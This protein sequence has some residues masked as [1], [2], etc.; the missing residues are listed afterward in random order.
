[1]STQPSQ[2]SGWH[3]ILRDLNLTASSCETPPN[4]PTNDAKAPETSWLQA[5][6]C[7][8]RTGFLRVLIGETPTHLELYV[9]V[10]AGSALETPDLLTA[11]LASYTQTP[12]N[13]HVASAP[14]ELST[15]LP[16]TTEIAQAPTSTLR[17]VLVALMK[18]GDL[19]SSDSAAL[20]QDAIA[21]A[22]SFT[23]SKPE[24]ST[25]EP[26]HDE[27]DSQENVL[28]ETIGSSAH[29][30]TSNAPNL[31]YFEVTAQPN[32][33]EIA[34]HLTTLL[35]PSEHI[36]LAKAI[37]H[38]LRTRFDADVVPTPGPVAPTS[39]EAK[40]STIRLDAEPSEEDQRNAMGRAEL[41]K[42]FTAF[43][44]KAQEWAVLGIDIF[45]LVGLKHANSTQDVIQV[46]T[47]A[48]PEQKS[49]SASPSQPDR[50]REKASVSDG[51]DDIVFD[52]SSRPAD[53]P[54]AAGSS[55][56]GFSNPQSD[57]L[58]R[59]HFTDERLKRG[60]AVT[61]LVDLVL[62]HPGYSDRRIGQV[63]SIMLS[64]DYHAALRLAENAPCVI[65]WGL[66]QQTAL[67]YKDVIETTGGKALLVEPDTFRER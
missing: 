49:T 32:N 37:A 45:E 31:D 38:H 30:D 6:A 35:R 43:F 65:A 16:N 59:G 9:Q 48:Q 23:P 39:S 24:K 28:F 41:A 64:I 15:T 46:T 25:V 58:V 8:A 50:T 13:T 63:L 4:R 12:W 19:I 20:T 10:A 21:S 22:L 3:Q 36:E 56:F 34:L 62:R 47:A 51:S 67:N 17:N 2:K 42:N 44:K 66:A 52:L 57:E 60:D 27:S 61:P 11:A 33:I 54:S 5:F 26:A 40:T 53:K 29:A 14:F 55:T 7:F 18:L 1:M